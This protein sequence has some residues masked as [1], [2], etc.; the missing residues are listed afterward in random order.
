MESKVFTK[1]AVEQALRL[2]AMGCCGILSKENAEESL[3]KLPEDLSRAVMA[4]TISARMI[5]QGLKSGESI[6]AE[7]LKKVCGEESAK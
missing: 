4:A 1:E 3:N 7:I 2:T 6:L 5:E